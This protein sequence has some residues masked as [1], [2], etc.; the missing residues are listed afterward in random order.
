M[1]K[2]SNSGPNIN[3]RKPDR[4]QHDRRA[5]YVTAHQYSSTTYSLTGRLFPLENFDI[6]F[7]SIVSIVLPFKKILKSKIA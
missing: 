7:K 3:T 6:R 2:G 5:A 1:Y 4:P